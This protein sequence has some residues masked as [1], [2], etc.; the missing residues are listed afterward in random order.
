MNDSITFLYNDSSVPR[1]LP[2]E[3]AL[4]IGLAAAVILFWV[5][6]FLVKFRKKE[7]P[8][9]SV[10]LTRVGVVSVLVLASL[11]F[12][13]ILPHPGLR[14]E[15]KQASLD[16]ALSKEGYQLDDA[17]LDELMNMSEEYKSSTNQQGSLS[18]F[19]PKEYGKVNLGPEKGFLIMQTSKEQ[20]SFNDYEY[21]IQHVD[22]EEEIIAAIQ[23]P[24]IRK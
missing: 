5:F 16:A 22:T 14:M 7:E 8:D 3:L 17:Q 18:W 2:L 10:Y 20:S 9:E 4:L 13:G 19:F 11:V 6:V 23:T 24:L 1:I 15:D 12:T 21:R